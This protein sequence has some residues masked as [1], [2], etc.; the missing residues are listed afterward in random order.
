ML[1][2]EISIYS[3]N[4]L[5]EPARDRAISEHREFLLSIM[6]PSDF[7]SGDPEYDTPEMLNKQYE[8]EYD[9]YLMHDEPIIDN[10]EANDYL[11]YTDGTLC[12]ATTYFG[13]H[14]RAGETELQIHGEQITVKGF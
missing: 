12:H 13:N 10:I 14:P 8:T 9:Y 4:E 6:Q 1:K 3:F 2:I 7:I 5:S 11:F